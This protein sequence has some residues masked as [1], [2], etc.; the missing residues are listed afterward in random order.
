[1]RRSRRCRAPAVRARYAS[2]AWA[3]RGPTLT[4]TPPLVTE[5]PPSSLISSLSPSPTTTAIR[6]A[7]AAPTRSRREP[8][9]RRILPGVLRVVASP[10]AR[11]QGRSVLAASAARPRRRRNQPDAAETLA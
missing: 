11:T 6:E 5:T 8:W 2:S 10:P 4:A 3:A 9:G 1:A 7:P